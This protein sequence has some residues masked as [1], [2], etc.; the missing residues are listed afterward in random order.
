MN[1]TKLR[2]TSSKGFASTLAMIAGVLAMMLTSPTAASAGTPLGPDAQLF[3]VLAD[4]SISLPYFS[5]ISWVAQSPAAP[6]VGADTV[7]LGGP[8]VG[9]GGWLGGDVIA[10]ATTGT[11]ISLFSHAAVH[12]ECITAG[13]TIDGLLGCADGADTS[14][15]NPLLATLNSAQLETQDYA[16]YLAGLTPTT[17]LGDINLKKYQSLTVKL[18][19]GVNVVSIGNLTTAGVNTISFSAPRG[20]VVVINVSGTIDLGTQTQI[21]ANTNGLNPH[22][23]IWNIESANPTFGAGVVFRGTLLNVAAGTT[24]TFGARSSINGALLTNGSV[25]VENAAIHLNFWPFTAAP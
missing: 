7:A 3:G 18:S 19:A 20:A 15:T 10:S 17:T 11:A 6:E 14:G 23:L 8:A 22:N 24:V 16:G 2:I 25:V 21:F 9:A 12:Q 4:G 5:T 1:C 13:G